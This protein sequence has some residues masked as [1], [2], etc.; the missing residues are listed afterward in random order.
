[1]AAIAPTP[2]TPD[3]TRPP[4]HGDEGAAAW[5]RLLIWTVGVFTAV[6]VI[7]MALIPTIIPPL[8]I[9]AVV[10]GIGLGLLRWLPRTGVVVLGAISLLVGIGGL[11]T[12]EHLAHPSSGLDFVHAAVALGGR[13]LAVVAAVQVLRAAAAA[14]ARRLG[15]SAVVLTGVVLLVG[16]VASLASTGE[17][18]ESG[19]VEVAITEH[20]FPDHTVVD[21]GDTLFVDNQEPFRHTYT[22]EGTDLDVVIPASQGVRIPVDIAPGTY[23]VICDIPGHEEMRGTLEVR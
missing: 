14:G 7:F 8:A 2:S 20:D 15:A 23:E 16:T 18:I 6:D 4:D 19:D 9:S 5:R 3:T 1:M 10:V 12:A 13:L 21:A 22:V 11:G 17:E